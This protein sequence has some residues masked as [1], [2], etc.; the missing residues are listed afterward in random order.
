MATESVDLRNIFESVEQR[1]C[2]QD[3]S[4]EEFDTGS[5]GEFLDNVRDRPLPTGSSRD[6][7]K[8]AQQQSEQ[9]I[10]L[11]TGIPND[12]H[13]PTQQ[14]SE[15]LALGGD[16]AR[17]DNVR[18]DN[19]RQGSTWQDNAWQGTE[20]QD[21]GA[22]NP[23]VYRVFGDEAGQEHCTSAQTQHSPLDAAFSMNQYH[24]AEVYADQG[25]L[26]FSLSQGAL[27][28][29]WNLS[30]RSTISMLDDGSE[31]TD[32]SRKR[33]SY[34]V[35]EV[36]PAWD[37]DALKE[38]RYSTPSG[39]PTVVSRGSTSKHSGYS[40][41]EA[42]LG[43]SCDAPA[44]TRQDSMPED[45][46]AKGEDE[47]ASWRADT[48]TPGCNAPVKAACPVQDVQTANGNRYQDL[49]VHNVPTANG[50]YQDLPVVDVDTVNG[51]YQDLP[52]VDVD[53]VNGVYQDLPVVDVDIVN[54][55]Y[56]DLP[57][58]DVDTVNGVYQTIKTYP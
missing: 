12:C 41:L 14:S 56:Q 57:V 11:E 44:V 39:D 48:S 52:V 51:V 23:R 2:G 53:T 6:S 15:H 4:I 49:Q 9:Y 3:I 50:V 27:G 28:Q 36:D 54:D 34:S 5:C 29:D 19:T 8:P 32:N 10:T 13:A 58:V 16:N 31:G 18:Q 24:T 42:E 40:I 17:Q 35:L 26:G 22:L 1:L 20:R 30:I 38:S 46:T 37:D 21:N 55:V 43:E 45:C 25:H 7:N 33:S 47:D